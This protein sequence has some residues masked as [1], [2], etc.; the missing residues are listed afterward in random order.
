MN[1]IDKFVSEQAQSIEI[2]TKHYDAVETCR[3][4]CDAAG[5]HEVGLGHHEENSYYLSYG[6]GYNSLG[7]VLV[8]IS[9]A[10]QVKDFVPLLRSIRKT[11]FKLHEHSEYPALQRKT[12]HFVSLEDKDIKVALS[13]FF[14]STSSAC[15]F[16][17]IGIETTTKYKFACPETA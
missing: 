14:D 9:G 16:I 3:R 13:L 2:A 12:F 1:P 11:G 8:Q 15:K 10:R 7:G 17:P 4:M 6:S 5:L